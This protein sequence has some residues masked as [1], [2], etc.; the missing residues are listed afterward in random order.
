MAVQQGAL[1]L[2]RQLAG[3]YFLYNNLVTVSLLRNDTIRN[4][5]QC[6]TLRGGRPRIPRS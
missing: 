3:A 1:L 4:D 6:K 5:V 2:R